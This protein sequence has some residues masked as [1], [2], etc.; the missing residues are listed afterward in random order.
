MSERVSPR[1][2]GRND[3]RANNGGVCTFDKSCK[4]RWIKSK[5]NRKR[6]AEAR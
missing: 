1:Q 6:K 5:K 4:G 3:C 2:C